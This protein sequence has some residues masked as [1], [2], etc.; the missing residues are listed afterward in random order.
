MMLAKAMRRGV[1]L[2]TVVLASAWADASACYTVVVGRLASADGAVLVGH[3]EVNGGK[4]IVSFRYVPRITHGPDGSVILSDGDSVPA[5]GTDYAF[6]WSGNLGL[7][8]SDS[9][10]N[11]W[12]VSVVSNACPSRTTGGG[13][14][15][16]MLRRLVVQRART[17]RE[18]VKIAAS[19]VAEH[20]YRGSQTLVIADSR[21][22]WLMALTT[23]KHWVAQRV[24][25]DRV[26]LLPN[27]YIT[28][29]VDLGDTA[30][31][32][33]SPGLI[34]HA[35]TKG[36]HRP[37]DGAF[38]FREAYGPGLPDQTDIRQW[39]GQCLVLGR[40]IGKPAA[41]HLP[42]SVKPSVRVSL[43][44]VMAILRDKGPGRI[45]CGNTQESAVFQLRSNM[46]RQV[47]CV[48]WR[49]TGP[50]DVGMFV[51][52]YAGI[53]AT[54]DSYHLPGKL[55]EQLTLAHHVR[56]PAAV[57]DPDPRRVWWTFMALESALRQEHRHRLPTVRKVLDRFEARSL[58]HATVVE[59][60]AIALLADDEATGVA[61]LTAHSC[62]MGRRAALV[63]E[64]L[65][66]S[67]TPEASTRPAM[68]QAPAEGRK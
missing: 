2:W 54:P 63:A 21:E 29:E 25:D 40:T 35:V 64:V 53:T 20:G 18:G 49:T 59:R 33:G 26:A 46:P 28:T 13:G 39:R 37:A 10:M 3:N 42:F 24:P 4:R 32:M 16:Y 55:R 17:A 52:W 38:I 15:G 8:H 9:Y 44:M 56:P 27:V 60:K 19:L 65:H 47:G 68:R 41:A 34:E 67:L 6:L 1:L 45:C 7:A 11:E 58:T 5:T 66:A 23:G 14:I 48:Y 31:F 61:L 43:A 51:P 22:A 36:Y 62:E 30:N 57:Y 12:G 50:P